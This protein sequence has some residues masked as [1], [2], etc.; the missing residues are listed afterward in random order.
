MFRSRLTSIVRTVLAL[1]FVFALAERAAAGPLVLSDVQV[2][3]DP[4]GLV[5]TI[6]AGLEA[7]SDLFLD[8]LS[9]DLFANGTPVADLFAGPTLLD[10]QP[11]FNLPLSLVMGESLA[12]GTVLFHLTGLLADT[13]YE[14][15]FAFFQF[16]LDGT[17]TTL[18]SQGFQFSTAA[19]VPEPATLLLLASGAGLTGLMQRRRRRKAL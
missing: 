7:E 6:T 13:S 4:I 12:S 8:A 11:F 19:P 16:E 2:H 5:A 3:V 1:A 9:V 17:S 18:A 15:T 14:G 10:T